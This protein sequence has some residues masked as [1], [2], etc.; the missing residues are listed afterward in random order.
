MKIAKPDSLTPT[1]GLLSQLCDK[2]FLRLWSWPTPRKSDGKELCDLIA[3]FD[4]HIFLFFDRESR[5][6]QK[7]SQSVDITWPRWKKEAIDKQIN[8]ANGAARYIRHG[9][10]VFLDT[11][12]E[13]PFPGVIPDTPIIHKVIVAHGAE[14]AC[15]SYSKDNVYG[16]LAIA[17]NDAPDTY[18]P[19]FFV[20]LNRNNPVHILDSVNV[21]IVLTELDTFADFLAYTQEKENAIQKYNI[22]GYCGEEDL[23]AHYIMNQLEQDEGYRIGHSA[24]SIN[25]LMIEEGHWKDFV[26]DGLQWRRNEAN[27]E[28]YLW[29]ELIQRTYQNALEGTTGGASLWKGKDALREMAREPRLS[30]RALSRR[31]LESI[32]SFPRT[33]K[34]MR[35]VA[36]M[37]SLADR[38]KMYVFLQ[39]RYSGKPFDE[40]REVRQHMLSIACGVAKNRFS[41]LKKIV[42]IAMDAPMYSSHDGE[43]F[44]LLECENWSNQDRAYYERENE[45]FG[46]FRNAKK[47]ERQVS[48]F[49]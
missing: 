6:L 24:P 20:Q 45:L 38:N 5:A 19:P 28:S 34:G 48:E 1:E 7:T 13:Q 42:G 37:F 49:E 10:S 29:D 14:E 41:H 22:F 44:A 47:F 2:L 46:F 4:N 16:S 39:F 25:A 8:T 31:M 27:K 18:S 21:K 36:Y 17:Y 43:D 9:G 11:R 12:C 15:K 26:D 40:Y 23:L 3:I 30:R 32:R 33:D 35:K